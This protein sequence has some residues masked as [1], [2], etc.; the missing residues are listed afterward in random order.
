MINTYREQLA[1]RRNAALRMEPLEDGRHDPADTRPEHMHIGTK[2]SQHLLSQGI[3]A[4]LD[5]DTQRDAWRTA[6]P[7]LRHLIEQQ[8]GDAA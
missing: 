7:S 4:H 6:G 3:G 1:R 5:V 8:A 2:A